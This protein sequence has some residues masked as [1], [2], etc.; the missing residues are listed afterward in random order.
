MKKTILRVTGICKSFSHVPVLHNVDFELEEA[1]THILMGENG[2]GKSTLMKIITGVYQQDSGSIFLDNGEGKLEEVRFSNPKTALEKGISMVF[3]EFNLMDNM[4]V[5]ENIFMGFAPTKNKFIDWKTMNAEAVK[6][7]DMVDLHISP[8]TLVGNLSTA[9]K[10]CVEIAKCL[11][12]NAKIIILDEPTSSLSEREVRTLF[13]LIAKLKKEGISIIYISHRMEEIFE[14]GDR[15]TVFRDGEKIDTLNIRETSEQELIQL[16]IGRKFEENYSEY[17][18][19]ESK[20]IAI[21]AEGIISSKYDIPVDFKAYKGEI[22]G[23][24]GLVGAGRTELARVLFGIDKSPCG[25]IKKDG[26]VLQLKSARDAIN[27]KIGMVPED[28]KELGLILSQDIQNNLTVVKLKDLPWVLKSDKEEASIT[29]YYM[30][31]LS[32]AA[33]SKKQLVGRLSGGNQ[34]KVV[35][36]KWLSLD[37]DVLILDEP[38]RGVDVKAKAEI[39]EIMR[40]LASQGVC[41]IMISSDLPE[42]LRVSHRVVVMHD[43]VITLDGAARDFDQEKIMHAAIS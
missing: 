15:V 41:I 43:G 35:I 31:A 33:Y 36:S 40:K 2:A 8:A 4:T 9:Q 22:V 20:E 10:Q 21:E 1:E 19:N 37:L 38:T 5:A 25:V 3:Q 39:Y 13:E 24:F 30:N 7:M 18:I 42:I 26:K 32:I 12:H 34:Q 17:I 11:S 29:D 23:I 28:R 6:W 14:I 27:Y 16:M